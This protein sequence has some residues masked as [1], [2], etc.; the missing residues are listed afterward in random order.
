MDAG[1]DGGLF[2]DAVNGEEAENVVSFAVYLL[3]DDSEPG[4]E[5]ARRDVLAAAAPFLRGYIWQKQAFHLHL[6]C[7]H[8]APWQ[9][10]PRPGKGKAAAAGAA[11]PNFLWGEVSFG[12]NIQDEWF[13]VS[14]L[15]H[16]TA[17]LPDL[18]ARVWDN[19]GEFLLIEA[20]YCLPKWVK[21]EVAENRVFLYRGSLHLIPLPSAKHPTIPMQPSLPE[22]LGVL[23]SLHPLAEA[24][25]EVQHMVRSRLAGLPHTAM[26]GMHRARVRVP[27]RLAALLTA[28]PQLVGAAAEAFYTR[29]VEDMKAAARQQHFP[30]EDTFSPLLCTFNRCMYAQ[31][32]GQVWEP[33]KKYPMPPV[34]SSTHKAALLG[35]KLAAGMEMFLCRQS[36]GGKRRGSAR[37]DFEQLH[38]CLA[39]VLHLQARSPTPL[40]PAITQ[41]VLRHM[42]ETLMGEVP[43]TPRY[44]RAEQE[45]R[46]VF[47]AAAEAP[48]AA[49]TRCADLLAA[50]L[51]RLAPA[52]GEG[53]APVAGGAEVAEDDSWL[54]SAAADL[55]KQLE[56]REKELEAY[57]QKKGEPAQ[58]EGQAAEGDGGQA[59]VESLARQMDQ[60]LNHVS[61][62]DGAEV[63]SDT[64]KGTAGMQPVSLD[65]GKFMK[66][67]EAVL[68][69]PIPE[70]H[71]HLFAAQDADE[72]SSSENS[73]FFSDE[74]GESADEDEVATPGAGGFARD[75]DWDAQTATDSDDDSRGEADFMHAY[76]EEMEQQLRGTTLAAT[77]A[78]D[79]AA[80]AEDAASSSK[81]AVDGEAEAAGAEGLKPVNLDTNL[82]SNL[83]ESYA[84]QE[85]LPGPASNIA[86][87][88]GIKL[89]R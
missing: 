74:D 50:V 9:K 80:P 66:E 29:D 63:P 71:R 57:L 42:A 68:G 79:A 70:S 23:R 7:R 76:G 22:A 37:G 62:L 87:M 43:G 64:G 30:T 4:A 88:L 52:G 15:L 69:L 25:A 54:S 60:F 5:A 86:G 78:Q 72:D 39:A 75:G 14:L 38:S 31:L 26:D 17:Q 81:P 40:F 84:S 65:P 19:D 3:C 16:A 44:E 24:S 58:A 51:R 36:G 8:P 21:P 28:H 47:D 41:C 89:P 10:P 48:A 18:C 11:P 85:G 67:L 32:H 55:E 13:I 49:G 27:A 73:S 6:S 61:G 2:M 83:L 20:A 59:E 82:I 35:A 77:F 45:A 34:D 46:A 12:D 1:A 56:Q 53:A 33:P